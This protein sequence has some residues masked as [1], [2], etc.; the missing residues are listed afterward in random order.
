MILCVLIVFNIKL[1]SLIYFRM[2]GY[3]PSGERCKCILNNILR[4]SQSLFFIVSAAII[5]LKYPQLQNKDSFSDPLFSLYSSWMVNIFVIL[6][7]LLAIFNVETFATLWLY[8]QYIL[9][10]KRRNNDR[11]R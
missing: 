9:R 1:M 8:R 2:Y 11:W 5:L 10:H 3:L 6:G 4:F 7:F